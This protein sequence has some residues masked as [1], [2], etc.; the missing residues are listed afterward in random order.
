MTLQ[1]IKSANREQLVAG[2]SLLESMIAMAVLLGVGAIVMYGTLRTMN[3]QGTITNRTE[4]HTSVRSAT[5]LLQQEIGQAGRIAAPLNATGTGPQTMTM[6]TQVAINP[7]TGS[8]TLP[9]TISP[10]TAVPSLFNGEWITV[11]GGANVANGRLQE[12]VQI[13]CGTP[14]ANPVTATFSKN[15]NVGVP[16]S[17]QG[18]FQWGIIPNTQ[19]GGSDANHLK[20]FGDINGDGNMVYVVYTCQQGTTTAPGYLYRNEVAWNAAAV[21]NNDTSMILL[22]NVLNNP[23]DQNGNA[24]PC[25]LYQIKHVGATAG[26][27]GDFVTNVEVTLTVQTE[28]QDPTTHQFQPETKALLNVSPRNVFNAWE[29][30]SGNLTDRVQPTPPTVVA[31]YPTNP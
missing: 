9:V 26:A 13:A 22:N 1:K 11:D 21:P 15:H 23:N 16:V 19:V 14:C 28:L 18:S 27:T 30:Y 24:F 20:M 25:F 12:S 29:L 3:T 5:E 17:V 6:L 2:F 4:M 7:V 10:D 31:L 8:V